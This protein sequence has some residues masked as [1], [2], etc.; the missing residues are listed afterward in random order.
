MCTPFELGTALA[1][2]VFEGEK[3]DAAV[4]EVG[5]GGR[6]DP[7]NIVKPCVCAITAIG[8]DHMQFLGNDLASI[9]GEKA[10]I[11]K[12]DVPVVFDPD[13]DIVAQVIRARAEDICA[14]VWITD[15]P[16]PSS[17]VFDRDGVYADVGEHRGM[18]INLPGEHQLQNARLALKIIDVLRMQGFQIP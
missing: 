16:A 2:S 5:M 14:P 18:R 7:T 15:Q 10:G 8:Y 1:L 13:D 9:T 6:L 17:I 12:K 4:I 3:V 11:I